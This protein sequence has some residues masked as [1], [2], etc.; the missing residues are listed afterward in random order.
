M[1]V[2]GAPRGHLAAL[3]QGLLHG[4]GPLRC[5]QLDFD[6]CVLLGGNTFSLRTV[7]V[8]A[9]L[10]DP[11]RDELDT[12]NHSRELMKTLTMSIEMASEYV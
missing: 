6:G 5:E 8:H 12:K 3:L 10:Q 7:V 1:S 9:R 4:T 2:P 11:K